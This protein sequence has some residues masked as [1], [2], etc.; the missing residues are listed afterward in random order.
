MDTA[1]LGSV[2]SLVCALC[3][4][5]QANSRH[6]RV[7]R[8]EKTVVFVCVPLLLHINCSKHVQWQ[9]CVQS[10]TVPGG[11]GSFCGWVSSYRRGE[12]FA[13]G[14]ALTGGGQAVSSLQILESVGEAW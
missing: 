10:G 11:V 6:K 5:V 1:I 13:V 12:V 9:K 14:C 7:K 8:G 3:A 2:V 4:W